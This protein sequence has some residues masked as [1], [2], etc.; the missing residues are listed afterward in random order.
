MKGAICHQ[1]VLV[2]PV[3][4][5]SHDRASAGRVSHR[6]RSPISGRGRDRTGIQRRRR[7]RVHAAS[8]SATDRSSRRALGTNPALTISALAEH[9]AQGATRNPMLRNAAGRPTNGPAGST[10]SV[11]G[12]NMPRECADG[13]GWTIGRRAFEILLHMSAENIDEL[14][15]RPSTTTSRRSASRIRTELPVDERHWT[16]TEGT[17]NVLDGRSATVDTKLLVYRLKLTNGGRSHALAPR[18]QDREHEYAAAASM[19]GA[20]ASSFVLYARRSPLSRARA[21]QLDVCGLVEACD[22]VRAMRTPSS[23]RRPTARRS[24]SSAPACREARRRR[25]S[26]RPAACE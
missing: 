4:A 14:L 2:A 24:P 5:A 22:R 7:Q 26:T 20:H 17:L 1:S 12:S 23:A 15:D 3:R 8:T 16:I 9:I 6:R 10:A 21:S 18:P 11:P 25:D 19:A 13:C